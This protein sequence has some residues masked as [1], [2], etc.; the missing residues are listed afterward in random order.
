MFEPFSALLPG[1]GLLRHYR[2][3]WH[4]HPVPFLELE[5]KEGY[6][7]LFFLFLDYELWHNPKSFSMHEIIPGTP[8]TVGCC[9]REIVFI[10]LLHQRIYN[11][12]SHRIK[13]WISCYNKNSTSNMTRKKMNEE[14]HTCKKREIAEIYLRNFF[15]IFRKILGWEREINTAP[16]P[17]P[18]VAP[19]KMEVAPSYMEVA[20]F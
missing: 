17:S 3:S 7:L 12:P 11:P 6:S 5:W 16:K 8:G 15:W 10:F 13:T 4:M 2:F 18:E 19:S 9:G 14:G 20:L 1:V